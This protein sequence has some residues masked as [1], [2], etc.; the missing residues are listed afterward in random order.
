MVVVVS[1][2]EVFKVYAQNR[3]LHRLPSR[4]S[5]LQ[6][7]VVEVLVVVFKV[8]LPDTAPHSVL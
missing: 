7:R 6:F 3:V 1:V 5:T 8:Y 4:T 2:E